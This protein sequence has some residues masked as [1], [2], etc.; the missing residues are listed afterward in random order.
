MRK[1]A[2]PEW[3]DRE[4]PAANAR[5][6]LP[7]LINEYFVLVRKVMSGANPSPEKLHSLRLATKQTRYTLELFR[8]CYGAGLETRL[9]G[10]RQIQALLGEVADCAA[11][12][13]TL[14]QSVR[15]V[16]SRALVKAFLKTRVESKTAEF[17][18]YWT[19]QFDAEGRERWWTG[20]L[21]RSARPPARR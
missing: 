6:G 14:T 15:S 19:E 16:T 11:A 9:E 12:Q 21:E 20:Y 4:G 1:L 18:K 5:R 3:D 10:L 2:R 13:R 8:S 17:R 7:T